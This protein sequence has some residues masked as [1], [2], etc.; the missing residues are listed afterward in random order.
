M[1]TPATA[2]VAIGFVALIFA[3]TNAIPQGE[4]LSL[5]YP[6]MLECLFIEF[7]AFFFLQADDNHMG[8]FWTHLFP[9]YYCSLA[10]A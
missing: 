8:D 6:S 2:I 10:A 3:G 4:A 9:P 5:S 1:K 7:L